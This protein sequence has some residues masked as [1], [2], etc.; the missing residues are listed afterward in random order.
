MEV[1]QTSPLATWVRRQS[2]GLRG[3]IRPSRSGCRARRPR[4]PRRRRTGL[5]ALVLAALLFLLL[6]LL[7]RFHATLSLAPLSDVALEGPSTCHDVTS[8]GEDRRTYP[9]VS[10]T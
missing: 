4:R 6:A 2:V 7:E 9:G 3:N 8:G 5:A 10:G 1:L